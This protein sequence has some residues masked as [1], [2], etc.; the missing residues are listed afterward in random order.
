MRLTFIELPTFTARWWKEKLGDEKL[1]EIQSVLLDRPEAGDSMPRTGGLRKIRLAPPKG[2][3]KGKRFGYR[4]IYALIPEASTVYFFA[5]YGK[6]DK[7]DLTA[8]EE[9]HY[10]DVL[11]A[12]KKYHRRLAG[13]SERS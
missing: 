13:E 11:S 5:V 4:V 10:R 3:G 6:W 9:T 12:L 8:A 7:D 1:Q 2:A